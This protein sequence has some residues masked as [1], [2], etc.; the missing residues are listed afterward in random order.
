M[1]LA[2]RDEKGNT[3]MKPWTIYRVFI[4]INVTGIKLIILLTFLDITKES[5]RNEK[6]I[7]ILESKWDTQFAQ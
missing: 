5:I 1:I 3:M 7:I 6:S 2:V 4:A